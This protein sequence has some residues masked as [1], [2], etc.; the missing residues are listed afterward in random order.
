MGK[1]S[2][3]EQNCS[4]LWYSYLCHSNKQIGYTS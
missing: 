2:K 3:R 1:I 4:Y